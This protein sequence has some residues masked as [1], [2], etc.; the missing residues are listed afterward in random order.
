MPRSKANNSPCRASRATS[1]PAESS[2]SFSAS[3]SAKLPELTLG[4]R[5]RGDRR[6]HREIHVLRH[7]RGAT[8][9]IPPRVLERDA[10]HRRCH[11]V[12]RGKS[13]GA[14]RLDWGGGRRSAPQAVAEGS[15]RSPHLVGARQHGGVR[16]QRQHQHADRRHGGEAAARRTD[17]ARRRRDRGGR[18]ES[19]CCPSSPARWSSTAISPSS[20]A[21][22]AWLTVAPLR[23]TAASSSRAWRSAAAC[24][25]IQAQGVALEMPR[26]LRSELDALVTFRPDPTEPI[27]DRRHPRRAGRLHGNDHHG[28]ARPPGRRARRVVAG[29]RAP[30]SR[31]RCGSTSSSRPPK[32]SRSTITTAGWPPAPTC[33]WSALSPSPAWMGGSRYA[34]AGRFIWPA[35]PSASRAAT[36]HSPIG[37]ASIPS[38]TSPP[39]RGSTAPT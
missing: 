38:S 11:V 17:R 8:A 9:T 23:S 32:T 14:R 27:A 22:A 31:A 35:T 19:C 16:R 24:V 26:G 5:R 15:R 12:G 6:R 28:R 39:T 30:V 4:S 10:H 37:G 20:T 25:N 1:P 34:R 13:A 7:S 18:T 33:A 2:G 3:G 29:G 36:F 21:S